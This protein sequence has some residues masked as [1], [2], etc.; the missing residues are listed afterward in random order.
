MVK[1]LPACSKPADPQINGT[2]QILS[3]LYNGGTEW[4]VTVVYLFDV[5]LITTNTYCASVSGN[6][7]I[8]KGW[9]QVT[10]QEA[11]LVSELLPTS[12]V[13]FRLGFECIDP[14]T[15][16]AVIFASKTGSQNP[17]HCQN[18]SDCSLDAALSEA[19]SFYGGIIVHNFVPKVG[20]FC[21]QK[22]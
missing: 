12:G 9:S 6:S 17:G 3:G 8:H 18:P 13:C 2:V 7:Q 16:V 1:S 4:Y 19:N 10:S 5:K 21:Q 14:K 20:S 22:L 11:P 15:Q